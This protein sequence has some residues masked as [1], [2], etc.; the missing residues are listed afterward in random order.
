MTELVRQ[1]TMDD[2]TLCCIAMATGLPY[3]Q[4]VAGASRA[5]MGYTPGK[6]T[7]S[8]Y[9]VLKELGF[10]AKVLFQLQQA[11]ITP[12]MIA[13]PQRLLATCIWGRRAIVSVP[14]LNEWAGHH[15]LYWDGHALHDPTTKP[16]RYAADALETIDPLE[17]VIFDERPA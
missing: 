12:G 9:W 5:R 11:A 4:V 2:C 8:T 3:D 7:R 14:S 6:G 17:V 1:R 16:N 15:D 13:D 10:P